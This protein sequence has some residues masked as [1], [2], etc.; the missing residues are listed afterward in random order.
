MDKTRE[1][2]RLEVE[3]SLPDLCGPKKL[4]ATFHQGWPRQPRQLGKNGVGTL[5]PATARCK[6]GLVGL[7]RD[8]ARRSWV[9]PNVPSPRQARNSERNFGKNTKSS[10]RKK[11]MKRWL[12]TVDRP[13]DRDHLFT[14]EGEGCEEPF[15][16]DGTT[17]QGRGAKRH[18]WRSGVHSVTV[19]GPDSSCGQNARMEASNGKT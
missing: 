13:S 17:R 4:S 19:S 15:E 3:E 12:C 2:A 6:I 14:G 5:A 10:V 9:V 1:S 8:G 7:L 16:R 11:T 18:A